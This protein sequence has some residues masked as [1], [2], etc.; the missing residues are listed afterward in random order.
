MK[1]SYA[2]KR[3][4]NEGNLVALNQAVATVDWLAVYQSNNAN[5][6]YNH[7]VKK[8]TETFDLCC[9]LKKQKK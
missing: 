4:V 2:F 3:V 1:E 5:S 7:F 6:A 8:Y 9:P